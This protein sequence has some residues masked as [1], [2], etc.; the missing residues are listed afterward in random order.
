MNERLTII[1]GDC[2]EELRRL[3]AE[4]VHLCVTSPPYWGLRDYKIPPS[5]WG[6][7]PECEHQWSAEI[8]T[9]RRGLQT[10]PSGS[11]AGPQREDAMKSTRGGLCSKCNAWRGVFGLEPTPELYLAHTLIIFRE[12]WRVLRKDGTLWINLGDSYATG[13]GA[14]GACPGG[15]AQGSR[16]AGQHPGRMKQNGLATNSGAG[17]GPMQQPNRMPQAGLKAGDLVGIPWRV[18]LALQADGWFLRRDNIWFKLNPMPES[19]R[20]WTWEQHRIKVALSKRA[21]VSTKHGAEDVGRKPHGSSAGHR[22][23]NG[24]AVFHS[25][26]E[27]IECLGC[28]KCSP[29]GGLILRKGNWRC[30]TSH[31]YVFQFSKSDSYFCDAEAARERTTGGAH[32]RGRGVNPKARWKTPDGWD[33]SRGS[34]GHGTI[35]KQGREK[36]KRPPKQNES[37]SAAVTGLV[38]NRNRRSVWPIATKPFKGAHFATFPPALV[39]PIIQAA[40][41]TKC[42]AKCGAPWAPI[43]QRGEPRRDQQRACGGDQNGQ[44]NGTATK[45]FLDAG[46]EDASAVKARILAGMVSKTVTGYRRTCKHAD[47]PSAPAVCLDPFGGSGT[48]G[49]VALEEGRAAILVELSREYLPMIHKRCAVTHGLGV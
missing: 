2:V 11:L 32:G 5:I 49:Q 43:V 6:G 27:F 25:S 20:G 19:V 26:A 16:W 14:V 35:H 29:N 39:R 41:P 7:D 44:Y 12:V 8:I 42:C 38:G 10:T 47:A 23:E 13:G 30:T 18:A 40:S 15:G 9:D 1:S 24:N 4:S 34:G 3:P 22:D 28:D 21:A 33:T 36:G 31:E 37:F 46:A 17:M 45:D 48:V